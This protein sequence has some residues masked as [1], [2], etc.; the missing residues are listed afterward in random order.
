MCYAFLSLEL[1]QVARSQLPLF[2]FQK[3]VGFQGIKT[4][5]IPVPEIF[6]PPSSQNW[7]KE[8]KN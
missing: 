3:A 4:K 1:G 8:L 2:W 6:Y 5:K 7:L